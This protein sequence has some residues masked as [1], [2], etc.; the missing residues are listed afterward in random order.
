MKKRLISLTSLVILVAILHISCSKEDDAAPAAKTKTE[1]LTKAT[2]K[3]EKAEAAIFGDISGNIEDCNKDN[4]ITFTSTA[5]N[6]GT[7]IAD[8]G[9]TKCNGANPQSTTFNWTLENNE[10]KLVSDKP[11]FPGGSGEFTLVSLTETNL[12]VSQQMT[13]PP[14]PTTMVTITLKH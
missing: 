5:N 12:V 13:I 2:W 14:A 4:T 8:E 3:F 7:G 1:L 11:L 9:A 6:K 10:T